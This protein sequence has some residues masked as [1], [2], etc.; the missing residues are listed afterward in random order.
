MVIWDK[1]SRSFFVTS[2]SIIL[3]YGV[4]THSLYIVFCV[5]IYLYTIY[6]TNLL[7]VLSITQVANEHG[8][9]YTEAILILI[10]WYFGYWN[11][12]H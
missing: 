10:V 4:Y 9:L 6:I 11:S 1:L 2:F 7:N 8:I 3:F 12:K 5:I